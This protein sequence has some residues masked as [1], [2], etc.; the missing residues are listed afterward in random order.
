MAL[1]AISF[2][3]LTDEPSQVGVRAVLRFYLKLDDKLPHIAAV[4]H[5][6]TG[7]ASA[8]LK[9]MRNAS[10]QV[11]EIVQVFPGIRRLNCVNFSGQESATH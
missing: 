7:L 2:I 10:Y 1:A 3:N 9:S 8:A 6:A 5:C 4:T 11:S